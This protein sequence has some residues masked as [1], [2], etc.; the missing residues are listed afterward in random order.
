MSDLLLKS[1]FDK[2]Q[3]LR[4]NRFY[5]E[6]RENLQIPEWT[7]ESVI[8]SD[9]NTIKIELSSYND[10]KNILN[11][12]KIYKDNIKLCILDITGVVILKGIIEEFTV[13]NVYPKNLDYS[14]DEKIKFICIAKYNKI[15]WEN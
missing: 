6:F 10:G 3:P 11:L 2:L 5:F 15:I 1:T 14:S 12:S 13:E 9:E 4:K 7:L 8:F